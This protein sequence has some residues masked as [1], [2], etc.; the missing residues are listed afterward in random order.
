MNKSQKRW[1]ILS[2][3]IS[4]AVILVVLFITFDP[5]STISALQKANPW[6]IVLAFA[7][8]VVSLLFWALRIK[9]MCRSLGYKIGFGHTFRL[10]CSNMFIASVTP[11]Q[12]GGEPVRVYEIHKAGVPTGDATAV[13]I[14]ERVFDGVVL[15]ICT[16]ISVVLLGLVFTSIQL[17]QGWIYTA[18]A[19]AVLFT[20]LLGLFFVISRKPALGQKLCRKVTGFFIRK[21][22]SAKT[23]AFQKKLETGVDSFYTTLGHFTGKSKSGMA[24]G[25]FF[26]TLYWINEFIITYV[27]ILG[28]GVPFSL[29]SFF[30]SFI[31]QILITVILMIPLTPGGAGVAE[32]SLAGFYAFI[33]PSAVLGIFVIIW[34]LIMYYFNLAVGFIASLLILRREAKGEPNGT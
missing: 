30:L 21:W 24:Y 8:H 12:V 20:I 10:V 27:V 11:S 9:L 1:L 18:Y 3:S 33:V 13:V 29:E 16:I 6:I 5:K 31:F 19:A 25:L 4:L 14:M 26:S 22:D 34:R 7:M 28:L 23:E 15:V 2:I 17:P 32:V